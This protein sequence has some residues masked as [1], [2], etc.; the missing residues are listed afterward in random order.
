MEIF[1]APYYTPT[2]LEQMDE[3]DIVFRIA[4]KMRHISD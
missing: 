2:Q 4:R 3:N 1:K